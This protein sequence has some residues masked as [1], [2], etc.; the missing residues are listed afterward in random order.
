MHQSAK[1]KIQDSQRQVTFYIRRVEETPA[2]LLVDGLCGDDTI[3]LGDVFTQAFKLGP[4]RTPD[5]RSIDPERRCLTRI[6][7]EVKH[8]EYFNKSMTFVSPGW[9]ARLLVK[10]TINI[11]LGEGWGF[12]GTSQQPLPS[13]AVADENAQWKK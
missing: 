12:S 8:I 1:S 2:G 9:Q 7:L 4:H 3:V 6:E 5:G 11:G 10:G 13:E